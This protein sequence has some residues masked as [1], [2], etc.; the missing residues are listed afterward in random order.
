MV[1]Q[2]SNEGSFTLLPQVL[3]VSNFIMVGSKRW[4]YRV[5]KLDMIYFEVQDG[6]LKLTFKFKHIWEVGTFEFY[7]YFFKKVTL[8]S[9]SSLWHQNCLILV[10]IWIFDDPILKKRPILVNLVPGR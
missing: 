1:N 4:R 2:L 10:K 3:F 9:L 6:Q 5:F 7:Q 8:A